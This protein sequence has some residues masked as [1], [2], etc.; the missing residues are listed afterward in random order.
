MRRMPA[1]SRLGTCIFLL[2]IS[3]AIG[4]AGV[5]RFVISEEVIHDAGAPPGRLDDFT[6]TTFLVAWKP[7]HAALTFGNFAAGAEVGGFVRDARGSA[8]AGSLRRRQEGFVEDTSVEVETDQ[9][10]GRTVGSAALRL[11]WPDRPE[12][13]NLLWVPSLGAEVYY[14]DCSFVALRATF[15]PRPGTG[16]TLRLANRLGRE[17]E[18]VE[19]AVAPRTD[20]VVN[21]SIGVRYGHLVAGFARERDFDFTRLDRRV[22]SIGF[23]HDFAP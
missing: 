9:V 23:H 13:D 16:V 3:S 1:M 18:Y 22:V 11:V 8:Y 17:R 7:G 19:I 15:D 4:A 2:L 21:F 6:D 10:V 20:G 12:T 14:R 5:E